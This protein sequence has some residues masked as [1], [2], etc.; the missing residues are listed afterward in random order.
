MK[1][2]AMGALR[3]CCLLLCLLWLQSCQGLRGCRLPTHTFQHCGED[4]VQVSRRGHKSEVEKHYNNK[5]KPK[6]RMN[7]GGRRPRKG[8]AT[9]IA[10]TSWR[11]SKIVQRNE[12]KNSDLQEG[13]L[14]TNGQNQ[15]SKLCEHPA[16]EVP[17]CFICIYIC[18][19]LV[20]GVA[21][22][23]EVAVLPEHFGKTDWKV[24]KRVK[25]TQIL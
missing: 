22:K 17:L 24:K 14:L 15:E 18:N 19:N 3:A 4:G 8:R 21:K 7:G 1:V 6:R 23:S 2:I 20:C 10:A 9:P 5:T 16:D 12:K 13:N 11:K 25:L